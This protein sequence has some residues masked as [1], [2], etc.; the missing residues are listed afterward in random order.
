M[1]P[2]DN[3]WVI[4]Q[5]FFGTGAYFKALA[6]HNRGKA[7]QQDRLAVGDLI[8]VPEIDELEED[9]PGLCPK[10]ERREIVRNRAAAVHQVSQYGGGQTYTVEEGDTLFD[11][12]RYE[13]G[14]GSRW[15]EIYELNRTLLGDDFDYLTP[16]LQLTLPSDNNTPVDTITRRNGTGSPYHR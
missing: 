13:L 12:A 16:G 9:Y 10:P 5:K 11:I 1:R 8:E 15:V 14:K 3:Y 7:P 4:S 6:E 2:N